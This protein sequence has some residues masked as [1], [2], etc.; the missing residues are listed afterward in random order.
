MSRNA[1]GKSLSF[2]FCTIIM[3]GATTVA[4]ADNPE[5]TERFEKQWYLGAGLGR[6]HLS[7]DT[8]G[9]GYNLDD[10]HDAGYKLF[11][12]YDLTERFT[13]ETYFSKLGKTE[14]SPQGRIKYKDYGLSALYYVYK[15]QRPH[16]G[17]GV[18]GRAGLGRMDNSANVPFSTDNGNHLMLGAAVEYGFKNGF[19]LRADADYYDKDSRLFAINLLKRFGTGKKA[20]PAPVAPLD[21]DHDGIADNEDRC[22]GTATGVVVDSRGCEVDS[23]KDGVPD[24]EDNCPGTAAGRQVDAQGCELLMDHDHDGVADESDRC[25]DTPAGVGVDAQ[26]CELDSDGDHV[27]DSQDRCPDTLAGTAVDAQ[28]CKL[29]ETIVLKGVTFAT[30][31]ANLIGESRAV[32]DEVVETLRR[33][34]DLRLEI[35]GYTDSRGSRGYNLGLSQKRAEAVRDYL[36]SREI[37]ADRLQARGYGPDDPVADNGTREGRAANRRVEL[38]IID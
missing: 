23:D 1:G 9:T 3:I 25:P 27:V 10:R 32:L 12:G 6:S 14:L 19:S 33:N 11:L 5:A 18:F 28:G 7:P 17:W 8:G 2:V 26:G 38:H 36:I 13:L 20:V 31:S 30:A 24:R 21:S 34:P 16:Q 15:S 4:A 35:A 22:P 37:A 29:H